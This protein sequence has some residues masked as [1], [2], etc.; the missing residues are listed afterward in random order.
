[1]FIQFCVCSYKA[2]ASSV[3]FVSRTTHWH[4]FNNHIVNVRS[5]FKYL[6]EEAEQSKSIND[7]LNPNI[8]I[9]KKYVFLLEFVIWSL[10][11]TSFGSDVEAF[12]PGKVLTSGF[13][14]VGLA[15]NVYIL[16]HILNI[17]N[18]I[19]APRTKF[20]EV[21]NQ[22]DAY[23]LKK[24]FSMHLQNRLRFFYKKKF[25][26]FYYQE[27]E[28]LKMLSGESMNFCLYELFSS[29]DAR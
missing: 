22:L 7:L 15:Y 12:I 27:D 25:R 17:I 29:I 21:M 16:I 24:Q 1:M 19:H 18:T 10:F 6:Y 26:K 8:P 3:F 23:M 11:D 14:L 2:I 9:Y 5:F 20:Y 4:H 13:M 28:I